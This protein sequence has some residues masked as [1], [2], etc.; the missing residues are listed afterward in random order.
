MS[1]ADRLDAPY[2]VD[3]ASSDRDF[4]PSP[5]IRTDSV[6]RGS[7]ALS[8]SRIVGMGAGF[9]LFLLLAWRSKEDVGIFRTA[10]TYLTISEFLPLLGMHRW[11]ATEMAAQARRRSALFRISTAL[12]VGVSALMAI[13]YLVISLTGIYS[14]VVSKSLML[15]AA[16]VIGSGL[17]MCTSSALV[18]MGLTQRMGALNLFENVSR[19]TI[20]IVL[21]ILG[22]SVLSIVVAF[23]V[24]RWIAT[25]AGLIMVNRLTAGT[26]REVT[27]EL[28]RSFFSQVPNLATGVVCTIVIR[29]SAMVLLPWLQNEGEAGLYAAPYQ[30]FDLLMLAPTMLIFSSNFVFCESALRSAAAL[31]QSTHQLVYLSSL[32]VF[33]FAAVAI[34]LAQPIITFFFKATFLNSVLPFQILMLTAPLATLDQALS[35]AMV[36]AGNYRQDVVS[37]TA[38]AVTTVIATLLMSRYWGAAGAAAAFLLGTLA[39]ASVKLIFLRALTGLPVLLLFSRRQLLASA[40]AAALAATVGMPLHLSSLGRS[41]MW[42]LPAFAG[43]GA[44][45]FLLHRLGGL[46]P[47]RRKRMRHFLT[48]RS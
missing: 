38:G 20:G 14:P 30:L 28:K 10:I 35:Q 25:L 24:M 23:V 36:T 7:I 47:V 2:E 16:A 19:S 5:A 8:V 9:L 15:V 48:R 46:S 42:M 33:P 4:Q 31:R 3:P 43:L 1:L 13:I 27:S 45:A 44:Y 37:T 12:A 32:Y 26:E 29:Y 34:A 39:A 22:K 40:I 21:V 11:L 6:V 41:P 17:S 18:G